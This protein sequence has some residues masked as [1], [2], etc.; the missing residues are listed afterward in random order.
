ME[1]GLLS[2]NTFR[3]SKKMSKDFKSFELRNSGIWVATM[4]I[5]SKLSLSKNLLSE[6]HGDKFE[7]DCGDNAYALS[8]TMA[9]TMRMRCRCVVQRGVLTQCQ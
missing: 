8:K 7:D 9:V 5:V 4:A 6:L 1:A 3:S 2:P